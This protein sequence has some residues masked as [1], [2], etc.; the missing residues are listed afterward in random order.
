M[1]LLERKKQLHALCR[2]V[3]VNGYFDGIFGKQFFEEICHRDLEGIVA[4][5]KLGIYKDDGNTWLNIKNKNYLIRTVE[6]LFYK[7]QPH[8]ADSGQHA[9]ILPPGSHLW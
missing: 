5:R 9:Q 1:P 3:G 6:R 8:W 2:R 4:K 7:L